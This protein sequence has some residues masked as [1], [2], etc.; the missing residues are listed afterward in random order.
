MDIHDRNYSCNRI[1]KNKNK[2]NIRIN[3]VNLKSFEGLRKLSLK[4]F[5]NFL[6]EFLKKNKNKLKNTLIVLSSDHGKVFA[7]NVSALNNKN[8]V[9]LFKRII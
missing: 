2:K 7:D 1:F 8:C 4:F 6:F 5:D 9:V 3:N